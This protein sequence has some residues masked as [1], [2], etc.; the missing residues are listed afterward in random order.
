MESP[1]SLVH[2]NCVNTSLPSAKSLTPPG[3]PNLF[4]GSEKRILMPEFCGTFVP[5]GPA[6]IIPGLSEAVVLEG[7]KVASH[8]R[9]GPAS[10]ENR[11]VVSGTKGMGGVKRSTRG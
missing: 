6:A 9:F 1:W 11:K 4:I 8:F 2:A 3:I 7:L 10:N 5:T